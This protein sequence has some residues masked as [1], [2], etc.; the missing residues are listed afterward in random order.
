MQRRPVRIAQISDIH[1]YNEKHKTLLGVTTYDSYH[2]VINLLKQQDPPP[3]L[4]LLTGDLTQ[5]ASDEAYIQVAQELKDLNLPV[6]C[7]PGNHD[8]NT[9]MRR[10]YPLYQVSVQKNIILDH[11]QLILLNSQ[12]EGAVEGFLNDSQ[13]DFLKECLEAYPEHRAIVTFHHQ[14]LP[15]G[16]AWL[17]K[18]GL[19]NAD[20]LWETL[21]S[22]PQVHTILCGHVH[23]EFE[24]KKQGIHVYSVPSTCIQFKRNSDQFAL[25]ELPPGYRFLELYPD[26]ELKTKVCRVDKY[27]G[28]FQINAKGY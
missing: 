23:Q 16:C 25:E 11:W 1:L 3:D 28:E 21:K 22:Y 26:G 24:G 20:V 5:D 15:V 13:I 7:I 14:P 10:V 8:E 17:D 27:I 9:E 19:T 6:Y 2:A 18:I 4:I 12:K